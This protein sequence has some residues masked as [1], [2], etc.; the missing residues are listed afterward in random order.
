MRGR[1]IAFLAVLTTTVLASMAVVAVP[2]GAA[3][4]VH[5]Q[6][7][8]GQDDEAEGQ[9][10]GAG[11]GAGAESGASQEEIEPAADAGGQPWTYQMAFLS[12]AL[13]V[14][15]G[16]AVAR[17]YYRLVVVRSRGRI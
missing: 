5:A 16:L 12:L 14:L 15:L 9:E 13:L 7:P 2:A 17:W 4:V 11:G 6:Q 3:G 10:G 1:L 8:P